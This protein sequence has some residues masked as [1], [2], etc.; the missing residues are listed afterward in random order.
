MDMFM[1][2]YS[3]LKRQFVKANASMIVSAGLA[4]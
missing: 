1:C 4:R 3:W 2:V